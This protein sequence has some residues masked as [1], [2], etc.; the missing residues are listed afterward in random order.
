MRTQAVHPRYALFVLV[1][2]VLV[3]AVVLALAAVLPAAAD[4]TYH[5]QHIDLAAVGSAPLRSGFVEN[6]HVNGPKIY[7][8]ERY[9]LN[10]A[11]PLTEYQVTLWGYEAGSGCTPSELNGVQL[12]LAIPTA[13]LTTNVSGNGVADARFTPEEAAGFK[14]I[15]TTWDL[16]WVL[17]TADGAER[18]ATGCVSVTLD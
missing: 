8:M 1:G 12:P 9:M 17:T 14:Q 4:D 2:F 10:G 11:A 18:Y 13:V 7:A 6:I 15:A 3:G 5:S 16:R